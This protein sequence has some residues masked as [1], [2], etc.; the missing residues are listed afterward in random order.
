MISII[1]PQQLTLAKIARG[2]T[3][4]DCMLAGLGVANAT[5]QSNLVF[6][7]FMEDL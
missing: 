4:N 1:V 6:D 3:F 2:T 7:Q 5:E